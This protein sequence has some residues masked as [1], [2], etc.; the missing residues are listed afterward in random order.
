[1]GRLRLW[2]RIERYFKGNC[3]RL[4]E[5]HIGKEPLGPD[6]LN[7]FHIQRIL[8]IRQH[9][10]LGDLLLSTPVFRAL[11]AKFPDAHITVIVRDYTQQILR[12][13][14]WID[15]VLTFQ[16]YLFRWTPKKAIHFWQAL[17]SGFDLAVVLNTVSHSL[18]SDIMA[19]LSG[20]P[21]VLGSEHKRFEG[22][23]RNFFYNLIAPY[24]SKE[25][26]Q[27]ERNL[28][29]VRYIGVDT[30]NLKEEIGL[31]PEEQE[32]AKSSINDLV[33]KPG[34]PI[35]GIQPGAGKLEN[36]WPAEQFA[37]VADQLVKKL[38]VNVILFQGPNE[39]KLIETMRNAMKAHYQVAPRISLRNDTALFSQLDLFLCNDTGV[40]HVA[41]SVGTP[42]VAIFGPTDP[43]SWKP[44]GDGFIAI[45]GENQSVQNVKVETVFRESLKILKM[46]TKYLKIK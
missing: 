37:E 25:K 2:T 30:R 29:I 28:D 16:E 35:L 10:Q 41:A 14:P 26:H 27:S 15:E 17:R 9:D 3:L 46:K 23:T 39:E 12:N 13:H 8:V 42:L 1:L 19:N 18:S 7:G 22:C 34:R 43:A 44:W 21:L 24:D 31:T 20:A 36:R 4:L 33:K 38:D 32:R 40:M 6:V 11:K 5:N 45:R